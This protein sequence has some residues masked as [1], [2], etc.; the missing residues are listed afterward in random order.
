M[1][2]ADFSGYVTKAG[3][4]CSDGR[5]IT[6]QAFA[7]MDGATVP[8]VWQHT[9]GSVENVLGHVKLEARPDGMYGHAYLN[10]TPS[11]KHAKGMVQHGDVRAMSI[12]ANQLKEHAKQVLHGII[13]EV[14]LVLAGANPKAVIDYVQIQHSDDPN[15]FT[16]S[17]E[18]AVI[19]MALSLEK[20]TDGKVEHAETSDEKLEHGIMANEDGPTIQQVYDAMSDKEKQV[21]HFMLSEALKQKAASGAMAQTDSS[22]NT[23]EHEEG[24]NSDMT[25]KRNVFEQQA[26][27]AG[28]Q[29]DDYVLTHDDMK[30]ILETAKKSGSLKHAVEDFALQHG[31]TNLDALFPDAKASDGTPQWIKRRT[32]W[33]AGVLN[34]VH[35]SPF[36]RVKTLWADIT[37]DE[38]RAKGY[39]TGSFKKE[40]FFALSQR[41]TTPTTVYK[42][43][44]LDRD[45]IIDIDFDVVPWMK[46]EMRLMLEEELAGAI[47]FGDGRD[48]SDEDK[49]KDPGSS[50]EGSGIRAI[51]SENELFATT[52]NVNIDDA[53]S[54]YE[55]VIEAVL[56]AR[57]YYLGTG[58]PDFYSTSSV[59]VEM[60]LTK[61][62]LG[63]RKW[64]NKTELALALNVN[65]II[66]VPRQV[67]ERGGA[68]LLGVLVN[69]DDYNVGNDRGG[70]VTLFDDFDIDYNQFKYLI[71]T[72]L[73][74]ALTKIKSAMVVRKTTSTNVLVTP[75]QPT[76]NT[77]TFVVTI[78]SQTGVTY[79]NADTNATLSSG[80]QTAL[81]AGAHLNVRA[82]AASGYYLATPSEDNTWHFARPAA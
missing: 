31:I 29:D 52:V 14:S 58:M 39:V 34:G 63:R 19:S 55:E 35:R 10:E 67:F 60:L 77:T 11:G 27:Q 64:N 5:T 69:L 9:H 8:L 15:D 56:R 48:P 71:E 53:S 47:I 26:G 81:S 79:K 50:A 70:E 43:Q 38:A 76:F 74:G 51:V 21:L 17:T 37:Y 44:K 6:P 80:A 61:D 42:K 59:I 33:V 82:Y 66:E 45:D 68:D 20:S 41:V 16:L 24:N 4:K 3:V 12:F 36:S 1:T 54:D 75:P 65:S 40:E 23:L 73:S 57:Q 7:H 72:R 30:G 46:G 18:E 13:R 2:A 25:G 78:P 22:D 28:K 49:I 32:E 62:S